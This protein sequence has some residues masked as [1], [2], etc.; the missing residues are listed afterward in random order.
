MTD[1]N[2]DEA[3]V[4]NIIKSPVFTNLVKGLTDQTL[5]AYLI[6]KLKKLHINKTIIVTLTG[7]PGSGKSTLREQLI[8]ALEKDG[9]SADYVSTDDFGLYTRE[10]RNRLIKE[11]KINPWTAKDWVLLNMLI[12]EVREGKSVKAPVYDEASGDAVV[13]GEENFPHIIKP[14]LHF[15]LVEGDFQPV[16]HVDLKIYFHV[17]TDVRRENRVVRDLAKRNGGDIEKIKQSFD[18]RLESQYYPYTLSNAE[19]AD[20]LIVTDAQPSGQ[21]DNPFTYYYS[22]YTKQ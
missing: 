21:L 10:E 18:F 20:V 1:L 19:K 17:P 15:L 14:R 7:G 12:D 4:A 22:V 11:G 6:Q 3:I 13:V 16:E 8:I 2:R 5:I 9:H